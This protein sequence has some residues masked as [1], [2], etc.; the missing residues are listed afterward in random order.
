M[1]KLTNTIIEKKEYNLLGN[2]DDERDVLDQF[3]DYYG[4]IYISDVITEIADNNTPTYTDDIWSNVRDIKEYIEEAIAEGIADL[5]DLTKIFQAGY[6]TFYQR[7]LYNNLDNLIYNL[8]ADSVNEYLNNLKNDQIEKLDISTIESEIESA[9]E[10]YDNNN[11]TRDIY[12][13]ANEII[14]GIKNGDFDL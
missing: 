3:S 2:L 8:I 4:D 13:K 5:E 9:S 10:E 11:R 6:Y 1:A 7:S 12:D 14:E